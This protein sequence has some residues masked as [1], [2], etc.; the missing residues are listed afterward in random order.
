[1]S[2]IARK[3]EVRQALYSKRPIFVLLYKGSY[4]ATNELNPS[5]PSVFVELL[6]EFDDVFPEELPSGYHQSEA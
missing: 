2:L 5:L 4:L 6:Q 1:M 3:S